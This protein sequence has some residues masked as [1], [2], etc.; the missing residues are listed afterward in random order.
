M[1]DRNS[2]LLFEYLRSILYDSKIKALDIE[3]LDEPFR[4]LGKGMQFLQHAVEEML[5]YSADLSRGNLSAPSPGMD[6][7][8]C[9]NLK[10]MHANLNHLTWQ[11][12]QVAAGDYSQ[13]VSYLGE[14]SAAF[15]VMTEQ[16][17][18]REN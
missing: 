8:L 5:E 14:F 18:E 9:V 16:L 12:K 15:N 6:N 2:E 11:A 7:F 10:N 4:K 13:H 1:E 3:E 17:K